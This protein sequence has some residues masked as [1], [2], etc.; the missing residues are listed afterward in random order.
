MSGQHPD[1]LKEHVDRFGI[2]DNTLNPQN[3]NDT[4]RDEP[5]DTEAN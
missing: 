3:M 5:S 1:T 2:R 4:V